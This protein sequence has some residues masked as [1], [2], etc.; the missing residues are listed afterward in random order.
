MIEKSDLRITKII[1]DFSEKS[2]FIF[3]EY[4]LLEDSIVLSTIKDTG[5]IRR[6]VDKSLFEDDI[7]LLFPDIENINILDLVVDNAKKLYPKMKENLQIVGTSI[8]ELKESVNMKS[9]DP[10]EKTK[11][12]NSLGGKNG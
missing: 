11:N 1:V 3:T 6:K 5:Y 4:D 10:I 2:I 7:K 8:K 9:K 12:I